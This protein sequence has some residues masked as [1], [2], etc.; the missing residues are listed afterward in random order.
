MLLVDDFGVSISVKA[1]EIF[2]HVAPWLKKWEIPLGVVS[3]QT[4]ESLHSDFA[5]FIERKG[6]SNPDSPHFAENL[7]KVVVAY[8]SSH[9]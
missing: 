9:I 7:L 3:E 1:H 4:S 5:N 8:N 6:V 2:F